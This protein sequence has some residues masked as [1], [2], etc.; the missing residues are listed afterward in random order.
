M[1]HLVCELFPLWYYLIYDLYS[2]DWKREVQRIA[3]LVGLV[4]F[5]SQLRSLLCWINWLCRNLHQVGPTIRS[6][7]T[8]RFEHVTQIQPLATRAH[9]VSFST[10]LLFTLS[11]I[12]FLFGTFFATKEKNQG[13]KKRITLFLFSITRAREHKERR[14]GGV[15]IAIDSFLSLWGLA[16]TGESR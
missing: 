3:N 1:I 2:Y 10:D 12:F 4:W 14:K 15:N 8:V 5:K 9:L 13:W 11:F 7:L 16:T 6:T